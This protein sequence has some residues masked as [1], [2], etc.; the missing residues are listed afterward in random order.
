MN[1]IKKILATIILTGVLI[2]VN[3][4]SDFEQLFNDKRY[5]DAALVLQK[6]CNNDKRIKSC[7]ILGFLYEHNSNSLIDGQSL[8][9]NGKKA[10]EFYT[11]ACDGGNLK[12]CNKV[13]LLTK[14]LVQ[15]EYLKESQEKYKQGGVFEGKGGVKIYEYKNGNIKALV[16][17]VNNKVNG[18]VYEFWENKAI[19]AKISIK[20]GLND[21]I[22]QKFYKM[23]ELIYEAYWK[24]GVRESFKTFYIN[25]NLMQEVYFKNSKAI[26]GFNY[27]EEGVK[28]E[29]TSAHLHQINKPKG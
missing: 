29:M 11:K 23:E 6:E 20:D 7:Q 9:G 18:T 15:Q 1:I 27:T 3:A 25:G 12:A 17:Y 5:V 14:T 26:K 19:K 22:E 24:N 16:P 28:S 4:S 8:G 13:R 2:L 21:G 10:K